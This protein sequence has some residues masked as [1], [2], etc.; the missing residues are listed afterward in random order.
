MVMAGVSVDMGKVLGGRWALLERVGTGSSSRVYRARDLNEGRLVAVK[1]LDEALA[2]DAVCVRAFRSESEAVAGLRH[3]NIVRFY[4]YGTQAV[5]GLAVPF[6]VTA[7]MAGGSLRS[8]LSAGHHLGVAQAVSVG[9]SAGRA[10]A[11]AHDKGIVH[12]DVKPDNILFDSD[13]V[14]G[15]ADFGIARA[16]ATA[17]VTEPLGWGGGT[18]RYAPPEQAD[19]RPLDVRSDLYSLGIVLIESVTGV[20]PLVA[21]SA[22][23]TKFIRSDRQVGV[24]DELGELREPLL[25]ATAADPADRCTASEFVAMLDAAA[26]V[27][28]APA[29][30]PLVPIGQGASGEGDIG[31]RASGEGA[32]G[33]GVAAAATSEVAAPSW[34][35]TSEIEIV[36]E[37]PDDSVPA[38]MPM[39]GQQ[40]VMPLEVAPG[41]S[42]LDGRSSSSASRSGSRWRRGLAMVAVALVIVGGASALWWFVVRVPTHAVPAWVGGDVAAAVADADENGWE[43]LEPTEIR[44]DGTAPGQVLAQDP[45]EGTDL[46]EGEA[47]ALTVS[48]G[49]TLTAIPPLSGVPESEAVVAIEAAGLVLGTRDSTFNEDAPAGVVLL[50]LPADGSEQPDAEGMVPK[51]TPIDILVSDG[52][53]P[54]TVPADLEGATLEDAR[55]SVEAVQLAT[56]VVEQYSDSVAKGDVVSV[57]PPPGT[58]LARGTAI[59]IVVS[60]GPQP[61]VV[62]DVT[63][64]TGTQAASTLEG[65]GFVVSGIEGSPSGLVLATDPVAGEARPPG[66]SVRIFTRR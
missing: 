7:F 8:M 39:A 27:A 45:A 43:V 31:L 57:S 1:V 61:I 50:A 37:E 62:P 35:T 28:G 52:P 21:E 16:V 55:A 47:I 51:R 59:E 34:E 29:P 64:Q 33:V 12:R 63:G 19:G 41:P 38:P 6:I 18:F 48:L 56:A 25:A 22:R 32:S 44:Q 26:L 24:S 11:Y 46:A 54:R 40:P 58:E 23:G 3:D 15:L 9:R 4:S 20:V 49:P 65:R 2:A 5:E 53:A 17:S 13:G 60:A 10:L 66:T 42:P 30:L 36:G 14:L